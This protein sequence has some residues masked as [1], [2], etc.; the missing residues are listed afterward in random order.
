MMKNYLKY[1]YKYNDTN[2]FPLRKIY[3]LKFKLLQKYF[4]AAI[5]ISAK[6][7]KNIV[8]PHGL[9]GIFIS[10]DAIIGNDCT[11][12]QQVTI[13]RNDIKNSKRYGTPIIGN[14]VYIG[15]D[16]KI[17]GNVKVGDNVKIGA[18]C[19]VTEDLPDNC[20]CVL[21]KNRIIKD[22]REL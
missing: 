2:F 13:G 10:K 1:Y 11:I 17:I 6:F 20:T 9:H 5:P 21:G 8:F 16:A 15:C 7:G 14:N 19:V 3:F 18:N 4:G 12:F 22:K